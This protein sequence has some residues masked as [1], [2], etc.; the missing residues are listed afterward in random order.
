MITARTDEYKAGKSEEELVKEAL[1]HPIGTPRLSEL[2]KGKNRIVLVT[3]DHTR[4]VPS[5]LTL[6][7]FW[8][9]SAKEIRTQILRF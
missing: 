8:Q 4:A 7:C 2:V 5:K 9:R 3:S 6:L 1:E